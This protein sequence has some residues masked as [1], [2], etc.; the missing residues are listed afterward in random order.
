M[1]YEFC[2]THGVPFSNCGKLIVACSEDDLGVLETLRSRASA[3]GVDD[4]ERL[5]PAK[6]A[7]LEPEL[8]TAGALFSPST[9]IVDSHGLML[10]LLGDAEA[11][12]AVLAVN[13]PVERCRAVAEGI[14]LDVGGDQPMRLGARELVNAAGLGAHDL[15]RAI[16]GPDSCN[17]PELHLAKGSYFTLSGASPFSRLVY[18]TPVEGGLGIHVTL[19][20]AGR[21]RFGPDVERVSGIAYDVDPARADMFYDAIRRYWPGLPDGALVPDYSGIRPK[22]RPSGN[23]DFLVAGPREHGTEGLVNLFGVESPGLTASLALARLALRKL[24]AARKGTR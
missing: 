12:G 19:D 17:V 8:A 23:A 1:L 10:A 24:D 7:A 6:V 3:N 14:V 5:D 15:G 11:A 16:H 21:C 2:R 20:L 4:L 13:C 9:G 18:P 22:L